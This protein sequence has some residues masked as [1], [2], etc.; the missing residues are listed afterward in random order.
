MVR[1]EGVREYSCK[2]IVDDKKK[3]QAIIDAL[4]INPV[5]YIKDNDLNSAANILIN[6]ESP[7]IP[8][9]KIPLT[10]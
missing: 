4:R 7:N 5:D 1:G 6:F 2:T 8:G 3:I 10:K 9:L